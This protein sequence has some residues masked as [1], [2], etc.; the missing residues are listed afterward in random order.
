MKLYSNAI[1]IKEHIEIFDA[2]PTLSNPSVYQEFAS[3][4]DVLR[5]GFKNYKDKVAIG[6]MSCK[7][8]DWHFIKRCNNCQVLGHFY[9]DCPTPEVHCCAKCSGNHLTNTWQ[10]YIYI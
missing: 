10:V 7:I 5:E 1:E 4:S 2:K 9:K 6:P 3:V 8:D